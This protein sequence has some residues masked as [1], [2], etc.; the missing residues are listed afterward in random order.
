VIPAQ[1][2]RLEAVRLFDN[3]HGESERV[4]WAL[5]QRCRSPLLAG[6][7]GPLVETLVW[8]LKSWW[9][10]QGVATAAKRPLAL[11]IAGLDWSESEFEAAPTPAGG[12]LRAAERVE[13]AVAEACRLGVTRKEYS[14]ISKV[15]H[16]LSPWQIPAYD[17]YVR[18]TLGVLEWEQPRAYREV[19]RKLLS[20]ASEL[21]VEGTEWIGGADPRSTLRALDKYFWWAG[22]GGSD[23][24]TSIKDPW[25]VL[26]DLG[27]EF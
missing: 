26:R 2:D 22:G 14:L 13:A 12:S 4:L 17:N 15:L 18:R 1:A 19:A 27:I 5:S 8:T 3:R 16:W 21:E 20:M 10:V 11:A 9:G 24:G 25:R 23:G 7:G 6:E